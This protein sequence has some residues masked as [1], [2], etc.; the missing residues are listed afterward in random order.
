LFS[1]DGGG[2]A[3]RTRDTCDLLSQCRGATKSEK[4]YARKNAAT[5][6]HAGKLPLRTAL[7]KKNTLLQKEYFVL[8]WIKGR[9]QIDC[10]ASH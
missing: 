3:R 9:A 6:F 5:D 2:R 10:K 1:G 8:I 4:T 7:A